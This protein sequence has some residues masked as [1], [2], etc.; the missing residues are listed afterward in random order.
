MKDLRDIQ[1]VEF[2]WFAIDRDGQVALFATAGHGPVP[3]SVLDASDTHDAIGEAIAVSSLGSI[4]V[5]Q[6]YARA[7]LYAFDWS[8]PQ[9]SYVRVAE[10]SAGAEFKQTHT[11]VAIPGLPCLPVSFSQVAVISPSWQDGT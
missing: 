1:G 6:S 3:A 7:G 10:P 5:W 4:A 8:E 11:V 2:D 9:G